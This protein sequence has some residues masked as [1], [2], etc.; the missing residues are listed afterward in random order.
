MADCEDP[1]VR[2]ASLVVGADGVVRAGNAAAAALFCVEEAALAGAPLASLVGVRAA[3]MILEAP[4]GAEIVAHRPD[5]GVLAL[6]VLP[7]AVVQGDPP[8]VRRLAL[9]DLCHAHRTGFPGV[10]SETVRDAIH[11]LRNP[12]AAA[13]NSLDLMTHRITRPE[14]VPSLQRVTRNGLERMDRLLAHVRELTQ[15]G[16]SRAHPVDMAETARTVVARHGSQAESARVALTVDAPAAGTMAVEGDPEALT[17]ALDA[18]VTN[19]LEASA[20]GGS[21]TVTVARDVSRREAV[22]SVIDRGEGIPPERVKNV[23]RMFFTTRKDQGNEGVGLSRARWVVAAHGGVI[24]LD[25]VPGRGTTVVVRL[26]L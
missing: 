24:T 19:A 6:G 21:V 12:L 8:D 20:E 18:V 25:S 3:A 22:I 11:S 23:F 16:V 15:V 14:D 2:S 17:E 5:G 7:D 10:V 9:A 4:D 26:P 13:L 1:G